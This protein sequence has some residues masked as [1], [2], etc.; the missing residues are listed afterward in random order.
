MKRI[1]TIA[2]IL[3]VGGFLW[4]LLC[5]PFIISGKTL[6]SLLIFGPGYIVTIGYFIRWFS[7]PRLSI[8]RAI[9]L[10][11][12]LVQGAWLAIYLLLFALEPTAFGLFF[13]LWWIFAFGLSLFCLYSEPHVTSA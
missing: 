13:G 3:A 8:R 12:L 10:S 1:K 7:I 5:L 4:G 11:S 6:H 2:G 9:W